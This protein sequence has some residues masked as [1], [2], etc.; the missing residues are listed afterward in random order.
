[1]IV[2]IDGPAGAG[3]SSIS[4]KVAFTLGFGFLDT[5]A[6]YRCVTLRAMLH[7]VSFSDP[8][9]LHH[10]AADADIT[11][12]GD[13]VILDGRDVSAEIRKPEVTANIRYI[14]DEPK[15]R[16]ILNQQQ[17]KIAEG[18]NMVTEGRDQGTDVFPDAD[19]KIYLTASPE[20]RARRRKQQL[21]DLGQESPYADVLQRLIRRDEQD[22]SRPVGALRIA[23]DAIVIDSDELTHQ[24][25]LERI[26]QIVKEHQSSKV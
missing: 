9:E 11:L 24:E 20:T 22:K 12:R 18:D 26:V 15:I 21:Q 2:T 1:M 8:S 17:R 4:R 23:K 3:K 7:G 19:C 13:V 25:V 10:V 5:G 14:A 6:M 16:G